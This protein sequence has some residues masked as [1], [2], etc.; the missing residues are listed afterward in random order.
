M[1]KAEVDNKYE[2]N[3][4]R[5]RLVWRDERRRPGKVISE[6]ADTLRNNLEITE[7]WND[8]YSDVMALVDCLR[9]LG[10]FQGG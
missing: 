3:L 4:G 7:H 6:F 5:L 8:A 9:A 10:Q 2:C 1:C